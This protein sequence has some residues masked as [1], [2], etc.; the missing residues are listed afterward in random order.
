MERDRAVGTDGDLAMGV[1]LRDTLASMSHIVE[2]GIRFLASNCQQ[3]HIRSCGSG[4]REGGRRGGGRGWEERGREGR[5][6]ERGM[7]WEM[8]TYLDL[9]GC[10]S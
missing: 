10:I 3:S 9:L 8:G 1:F 5:S 6:E 4:G 2:N 7:G